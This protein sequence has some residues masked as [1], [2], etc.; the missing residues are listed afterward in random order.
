MLKDKVA[1]VVNPLLIRIIFLLPV[2]VMLFL[3]ACATS[4]AYLDRTAEGKIFWPGPPAKAR[5]QYMWTIN[6]TP[7]SGEAGRK[8]LADILLGDVVD[9]PSD[10]RAAMSL[11]RPFS[12]S[13]SSDGTKLY[14]SDTGALR[15]TVIDLKDMSTRHILS[16]GKEE[17]LSPVGVAAT[18]TGDIYI[19]DSDLKKVFILSEDGKLKGEL[20]KEF[21]RPTLLAVDEERHVIYVSDTAAH[22][23]IA[24]SIVDGS[25]VMEIGKRGGEDG[26]FNFPT[27]LWVDDTGDLYVTDAMNFRVQIFDSTGKFIS[28]FGTLGDGS[29][30]LE[31]PKGVATD[32]ERNV[33]VVDSIN[34][35]VKIFNREG[36]LLLQ[37]GSEGAGYGQFWLPGG[38]F[39]DNEDH[40]YVADVY[41]NRVQV[42]RFIGVN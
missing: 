14:I 21:L 23:V 12:I 25:T 4:R 16:A 8:G 29:G 7:R 2:M 34:D 26:E 35:S 42:F 39:I 22:K 31:K 10:P 38:M 3:P 5:I 30:N 1:S 18:P 9:D 17:F 32:S 36:Q 11:L 37:F 28:K 13:M 40:I 6:T 41:N 20:K 15:V 33:Y 27:H 19:S 24:F